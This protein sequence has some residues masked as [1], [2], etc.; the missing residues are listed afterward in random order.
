MKIK[1]LLCLT[2]LLLLLP[3]LISCQMFSAQKIQRKPQSAG[4][5]GYCSTCLVG[6]LDEDLKELKNTIQKSNPNNHPPV[7][8]PIEARSAVVLD[9]NGD[10]ICRVDFM[11]HPDLVPN[12]AKPITQKMVYQKIIRSQRRPASVAN[13]SDLPPCTGKYLSQLKKVAKKNVVINGNESYIHKVKLKKNLAAGA[14]A[15]FIGASS[16]YAIR[17]TENTTDDNIMDTA[18]IGGVVGGYVIKKIPEKVKDKIRNMY[19]T[20]QSSR[21]SVTDTLTKRLPGADKIDRQM[22][23]KAVKIGAFCYIGT[24]IGLVLYDVYQIIPIIKEVIQ[25]LN[26]TQQL[27]D[28]PSQPTPIN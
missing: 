23:K 26:E 17:A 21:F 20:F 25:E 1:R 18:I 13:E 12:F 15:C 14:A 5:G 6:R 24:E 8:T 11:E 3:V 9:K 19:H 27:N 28:S 22:A 2:Y 7:K 16:A 4:F 10:V